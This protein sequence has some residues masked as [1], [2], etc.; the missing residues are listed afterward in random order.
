MSDTNVHTGK[1]FCG[2]V[3]LTVT[4]EPVAM[5]YC[6]CNS[7]REWSASPVN[8]FTLWSPEAVQITKGVDNIGSYQKTPKSIRKW[9]STLPAHSRLL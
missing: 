9:C 5:G 1:C 3:E 4:G 7:C 2:A 8:A 6:H